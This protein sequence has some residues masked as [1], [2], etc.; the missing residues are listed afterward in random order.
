MALKTP[1][2]DDAARA[3]LTEQDAD[4]FSDQLAAFHDTLD[5][6][7]QVLLARLVVEASDGELPPSDKSGT[8]EPPTE[9]EFDA[10]A[11]KLSRFHDTLAGDQHLFLDEMLGKTWFAAEA[12]VEGYHWRLLAVWKSTD[13]VPYGGY[14][15]LCRRAGGDRLSW[16]YR[17][18]TA[19]V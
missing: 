14:R 16:T 13:P 9:D 6:K 11:E 17:R 3:E 2:L 1:V 18:G 19:G 5:E 4:E 12:E 15:D 7:E 8:L 10:F